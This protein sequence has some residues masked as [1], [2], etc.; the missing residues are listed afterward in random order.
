MIWS[1]EP[2][3]SPT[4]DDATYQIPIDYGYMPHGRILNGVRG[5]EVARAIIS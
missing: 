4:L 3:P 2:L 5:V 1:L